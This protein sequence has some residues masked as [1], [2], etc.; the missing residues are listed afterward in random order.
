MF[1][2]F[3]LRQLIQ[4]YT[5]EKG[6]KYISDEKVNVTQVIQALHTYLQVN[7]INDVGMKTSTL[8]SKFTEALKLINEEKT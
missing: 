7:N 5:S 8:Q 1:L 3:I 6:A 4:L 2:I